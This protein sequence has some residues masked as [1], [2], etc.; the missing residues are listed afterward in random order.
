[1]PN[2]RIGDWAP[3]GE[4][5]LLAISMNNVMRLRFN[6]FLPYQRERIRDWVDIPE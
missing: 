3:R 6:P 5:G 4:K 2:I 1:M